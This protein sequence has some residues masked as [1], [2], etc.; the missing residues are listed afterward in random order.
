MS[1]LEIYGPLG[2]CVDSTQQNVEAKGKRLPWANNGR[3]GKSPALL[4]PG[5]ARPL[6]LAAPLPLPRRS[7]A[8]RGRRNRRRRARL[9]N[10][11]GHKG[12]SC[13]LQSL[14]YRSDGSDLGTLLTEG[15]RCG[16]VMHAAVIT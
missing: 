13:R 10:M 2:R 16:K 1:E 12:C 6:S 15:A 11:R 8:E 14:K 9:G 5:V 4:F 7:G 3:K